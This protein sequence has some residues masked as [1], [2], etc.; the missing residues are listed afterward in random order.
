MT[1]TCFG[2]YTLPH[3]LFFVLHH[4]FLGLTFVCC[5][6]RKCHPGLGKGSWLVISHQHTCSFSTNRLKMCSTICCN[7]DEKTPELY[8]LNNVKYKIPEKK[9]SALNLDSV[10]SQTDLPLWWTKQIPDLTVESC[11]FY[12][13]LLTQDYA[14][15]NALEIKEVVDVRKSTILRATLAKALPGDDSINSPEAA[16]CSEYR[17]KYLFTC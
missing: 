12:V 13:I 11:V 15:E 2:V 4:V 1:D 3:D 8:L 5:I 6:W 10:G 14:F 9:K 7:V 17:A 16:S